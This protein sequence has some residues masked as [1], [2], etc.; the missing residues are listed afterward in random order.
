LKN[1]NPIIFLSKWFI[2]VCGAVFVLSSVLKA[3]EV[4]AF[5]VQ[6]SYYGLVKQAELVR[7]LALGVIGMEAA[8]GLALLFGLWLRRVT[9]PLTVGILLGF[10]G[11]LFYA[12]LHLDLGDC[13][14]FGIYI[15]MSPPIS[16]LKNVLLIVLFGF[17]WFGL[18]KYEGREDKT[19]LGF[20]ENH[21]AYLVAVLSVGLVILSGLLNSRTAP[22]S[23]IKDNSVRVQP[24]DIKERPFA[25]FNFDYEGLKIDLGTGTYLVAMLSDT[26]EHC[27]ESVAPLNEMLDIPGFPFIVGLCLGEKGTFEE[28]IAGYQPKFPVRLIEPLKF[29]E[30]IGDAPPRFILVRDGKSI[31]YWDD[32]LPKAPEILDA[33]VD[34]S[35]Q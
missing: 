21:K 32:E 35:P 7:L 14:C 26:C 4:D 6:I 18:A 34:S 5:A 24:L 3:L 10:T 29:F 2:L 31:H 25:E 8:I 12:W 28:F 16:I 11:V 20:R 23:E 33:M 22:I 27:G 9:I 1:S 13:G 19:P 15:P 30:H 17:A